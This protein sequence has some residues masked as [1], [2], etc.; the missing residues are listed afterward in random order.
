M[1]PPAMELRFRD[2]AVR[3][4]RP[5]HDTPERVLSGDRRAR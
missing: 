2:R 3:L 1:T 4:G 5:D